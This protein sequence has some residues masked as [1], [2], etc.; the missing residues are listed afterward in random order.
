MLTKRYLP[1][2]KNLPGVLEKI[3]DGTAPEKFTTEHLKGLGFKSSN[4][5]AIIPLLK[6]LGFLSEDGSPTQR[7]HEYRDKSR[8]RAIL[9]EALKDA[10]SDLFHIREKPSAADRE[11]VRGKFK[12]VH[13]VSDR[14][15]EAQTAT[16]LA[17]LKL[18]DLDVV[19]TKPKT[20]KPSEKEAPEGRTVV[21]A[22][23]PPPETLS[24]LSLR[25]NIEIHLPATKDVEVYNAIFKALRSHLGE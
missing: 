12:T 20:R 16:F 10:Y 5:R 19:A 23:P 11:A 18:A 21:S 1:S 2:T 9:G 6:D 17:L 24:A 8:S 3:I 13:N 4:D 14:V 25:Y 22:T 7:Y 15:A